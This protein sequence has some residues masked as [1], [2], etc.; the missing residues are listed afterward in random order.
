MRLGPSKPVPPSP[1][2]RIYRTK[3]ISLPTRTTQITCAPR[4]GPAKPHPNPP[5]PQTLEPYAHHKDMP[6]NL[7][8]GRPF[9]N[10]RR[11]VGPLADAGAALEIG[12]TKFASRWSIGTRS[13]SSS[14]DPDRRASPEARGQAAT[15]AGGFPAETEREV[16]ERHAR[17][18]AIAE[19]QRLPLRDIFASVNC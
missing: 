11:L 7:L 18:G 17:A 8:P 5:S 15:E 2:T 6:L 3:P 12:A 1:R 14:P 16:G 19:E 9:G 13:S 10:E 4:N